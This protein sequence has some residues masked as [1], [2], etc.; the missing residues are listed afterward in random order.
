[1]SNNSLFIY[2]LCMFAFSKFFILFSFGGTRWQPMLP[3]QPPWPHSTE[4][5]KVC[6]PKGKK[7]SPPRKRLKGKNT[8][9]TTSGCS[10]K[11]L[12]PTRHGAR[13]KPQ[14]LTQ[15]TRP[16]EPTNHPPKASS[17]QQVGG[18]KV[19]GRAS[20]TT[21]KASRQSKRVK[22]ATPSPGDCHDR[23]ARLVAD[24]VYP[25][26]SHLSGTFTRQKEKLPI[27]S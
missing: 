2:V 27:T 16:K 9:F 22:G 24:P 23:T 21:P 26:P 7:R 11:T 1:M 5:N 20:P 18:W 10:R 19:S 4:R 3:A 12:N 17:Y 25:K 13:R 8:A 15:V 14:H 6:L